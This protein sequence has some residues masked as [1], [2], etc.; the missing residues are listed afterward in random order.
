MVDSN[1]NKQEHN[2]P[3][4]Q[5]SRNNV[6]PKFLAPTVISNSFYQ[7]KQKIPKEGTSTF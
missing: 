7:A 5:F 4:T 3:I 2:S 6:K 1:N